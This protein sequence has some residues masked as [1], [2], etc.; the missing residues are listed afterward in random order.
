M[1]KVFESSNCRQLE[2]NGYNGGTKDIRLQE[3]NRE[4][5]ENF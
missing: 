4:N 1:S 2:P 3:R 5:K